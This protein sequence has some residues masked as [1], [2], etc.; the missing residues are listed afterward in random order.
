[1]A[2]ECYY[3]ILGRRLFLLNFQWS[4]WNL[5]RTTW[6]WL[7]LGNFY[8]RRPPIQD[9]ASKLDSQVNWYHIDKGVPD[10]SF[11]SSS[12]LFE[13]YI[14]GDTGGPLVCGEG[15][16]LLAGIVSWGMGCG[17]GPQIYTK[18]IHFQFSTFANFFV[19]HFSRCPTSEIGWIL[20]SIIIIAVSIEILCSEN[21]YGCVYSWFWLQ[22]STSP[23]KMYDNLP[24]FLSVH[25]KLLRHIFYPR[26]PTYHTDAM[27]N[28]I[29]IR[30][31][32]SDRYL[33]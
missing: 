20:R 31:F 21:D 12:L 17:K 5:C 4:E 2:F 33:A 22:Q 16:N 7:L 9:L 32:S 29:L 1:M 26:Q 3:K 15:M 30:A 23:H 13:D 25:F 8:P 18:V 28:I 19:H 24:P 27:R 11:L 14:Q 10:L 6:R